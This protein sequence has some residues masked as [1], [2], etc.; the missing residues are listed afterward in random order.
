MQNKSF[1]KKKR[2]YKTLLKLALIVRIEY[3]SSN[4]FSNDRITWNPLVIDILEIL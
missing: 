4:E 3:R 2:A 1:L